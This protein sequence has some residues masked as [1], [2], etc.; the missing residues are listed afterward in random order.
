MIG[1]EIRS[2]LWLKRSPAL[3]ENFPSIGHTFLSVANAHAAFPVILRQDE[4]T[5]YAKLHAMTVILADRFLA[6]GVGQ[7]SIVAVTTNDMRM[8]LGA[9]LATSLIGARF[10]VASKT[11]ATCNVIT[12]THRYRTSDAEVARTSAFHL[13][14]D[15]VFSDA[16]AA[17]ALRKQSYSGPSDPEAPWLY[18][19]TSGT[20]GTP[21]YI[22]LS[23]RVVADRTRAVAADFPYAST[24]MGTL[25]GVTSRPFYARAIGILLNAGTIVESVNLKFWIQVG[26]NYACASP[27]QASK[28]LVDL[29]ESSPKLPR[30][31][32]S[33]AKLS[34]EM[35]RV[36]LR[37]FETVTDIYGA[38]ETNKSFATEIF[39]EDGVSCPIGTIGQVRV[40]NG[41][42][43]PGY[44]ERPDATEKS[45]VEGWFV[46][47]DWAKWG[48]NGELD[49]IGRSDDVV[50]I[51]GMKLNAHLVD[52]VVRLTPGVAD[53]TAFRNPKPGAGN[54]LVVF[55]KFENIVDRQLCLAAVRQAL[56]NQLGFAIP[57]GNLHTIDEIP[58]DENGE[59]MRRVCQEILLKRVTE[60]SLD[61]ASQ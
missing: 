53:A 26:V 1:S 32:V 54:E 31:E 52:L 29:P 47:G 25:F 27:L 21:K 56:D 16:A 5:T 12:P 45:F 9:L 48:P 28:L 57:I 17:A 36:L 49:V 7:N 6:D 58:H 15:A 4:V 61:K 30:L 60:K 44:V 59:P 13:I 41:Y 23:Q 38:S 37:H 3:L 19:H 43:V 22:A 40:R 11:L 24:T 55:I 18:L 35:A 2:Q 14:G 34:D 33:G 46:P 51:G 39:D 20:T 42:M 8:S 10:V 50:S